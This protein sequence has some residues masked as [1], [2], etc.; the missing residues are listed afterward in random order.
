MPIEAAAAVVLKK[1]PGM[2]HSD[3]YADM[4]PAEAT[5]NSAIATGTP[6]SNRATAAS[7]AAADKRG[8]AACQRRSPVLSERQPQTSIAGIDTIAG[9]AASK[10]TF[11]TLMPPMR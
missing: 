1:L 10:A 8:I 9:I 7:A 11:V 6:T 3:G 5:A 4:I 2:A